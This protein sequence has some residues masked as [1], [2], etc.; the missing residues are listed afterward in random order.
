[1]IKYFFEF[2]AFSYVFQ[3][4]IAI[5]R[6]NLGGCIYI[7]IYIYIYILQCHKRQDITYNN[8]LLKYEIQNNIRIYK[9][10][11]YLEY[12]KYDINRAVVVLS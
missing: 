1:M 11:K 2:T 6:M 5:F 7:Y 12:I 9:Y 3:L 4:F 10:I 8:K